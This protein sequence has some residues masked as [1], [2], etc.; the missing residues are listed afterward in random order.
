MVLFLLDAFRL[1][2]KVLTERRTRAVLTIIGVAI[3]PLA[4]VMISS[5]VDGYGDYIVSQI[6]GLG[7]NVVVLFPEQGYRFSEKDLDYVRSLPGVKRAEPFYSVQAQVAIGG[8]KKIVYVYAL[9]IDVVFEAIKKLEL[10]EGNLPSES[11]Y[12]KAVVGYKIAY[13]DYGEKICGVGDAVTLT[14]I[15]QFGDKSEVKRAIVVV[16]GV[17]SEFGGAFLLSPDT[18][19]FLPLSAGRRLLG[20]NEWSGI[21]VLAETSESVPAV[22]KQLQ[23]DYR[24]KASVISFQS[25][26]NTVSSVVG[27]VNF[28]SF[29]A[30]LSAFAVAVAGIAATMITSVVERTREIGVMKALGFTDSQVLVMI[31]LESIVM[32]IIGG[33]IGIA[34]GVAGAHVLASVGFTLR[35]PTEG[36]VVIKAPP[37]IT[38]HNVMRAAALTLAVSVI[39][40]VFPAYRA[41]KIP[42]AVALRYE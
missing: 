5:V 39:G 25:I 10:T 24:G 6:E 21:F 18:T 23:E 42:P 17:L 19:I 13:N 27:A 28:V 8:E 33:L 32:G 29:A 38:P 14:Y 4:L 26:A 35:L 7:Q 40:G 3:G 31:L 2:F 15:R 16:E 12:L 11:D 22:V 36:A 1:A 9:P 34:V 20:L 41:S 37:K 30:S